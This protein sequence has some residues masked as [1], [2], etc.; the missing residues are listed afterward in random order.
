MSWS[1]RIA[2]ALLLAGLLP[3]LA[4]CGFKPLYGRDSGGGDVVP[5][6][7][8]IGIEQPNDRGEQLFRNRLLDILTPKGAPDRPRYLLKYRIT[9]SL[10][11]VFVTRSEEITRS[12]LQVS[13]AT[14]LHDYESGRPIFSSSATSQ[15]S[16]NQTT[17]DYAN[18][19]SE[20]D[21]RDRAMRDAAEQL[22]IRL[23]NYFDRWRQEAP[24]TT[25]PL[26]PL[27]R[28]PA[29]MAQ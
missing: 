27:P 24:R 19:I 10:G 16:F 29:S 18:L 4:G 28:P 15:A 3:A 21:A 9:E 1:R 17:N 12:N 26:Q 5:E 2:A 8:Q 14:I 13:I 20:R 22:R 23:A 25:P 6:F 11:S 7:A